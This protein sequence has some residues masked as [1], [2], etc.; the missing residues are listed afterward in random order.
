MRSLWLI[1]NEI[2]WEMKFYPLIIY[3][4]KQTYMLLWRTSTL[5][6]CFESAWSSNVQEEKLKDVWFGKVKGTR[7]MVRF[8]L[9]GNPSD[10]PF[11]F[12]SCKFFY[13][14]PASKQKRKIRT[15]QIYPVLCT[16]PCDSAIAPWVLG[17]KM[18]VFSDQAFKIGHWG[19]FSLKLIMV[20]FFEFSFLNFL[21][22]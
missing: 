9:R 21:K 12:N 1:S 17:L 6:V 10:T 14:L 13:I 2:K 4:G 11:S 16:V 3:S 22:S 18:T 7:N 19:N 20:Q 8:F 15:R 5:V